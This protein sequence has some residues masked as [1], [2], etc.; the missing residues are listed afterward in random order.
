MSST[1]DERLRF[2]RKPRRRLPNAVPENRG[3]GG[4]TKGEG[5][6]LDGLARLFDPKLRGVGVIKYYITHK[7]EFVLSLPISRLFKI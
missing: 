3:F 5:C 7:H 6:V 2:G 1:R 4:E